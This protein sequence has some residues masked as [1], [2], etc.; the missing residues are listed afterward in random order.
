VIHAIIVTNLALLREGLKALLATEDGLDVT[1]IA[2][3]E[4]DVLAAARQLRPG[5][6]VVD[7]DTLGRHGLRY[8]RLLV[9][10]LPTTAVIALTARHSP[11]LLRQALAAGARGF[12]STEQ[13]P[14]ELVEV[15]R[16]VAEGDRMIHSVTALA[17]LA[18]MNS[19]LSERECEVLRLAAQGLSSDMI[20][21]KLFLSN[22]TVRNYLS[23]AVRKLGCANRLQA[24]RRAE[25]AGWL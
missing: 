22:G 19:P 18:T 2:G 7:L 20:A 24:A 16:R 5:V 1:G 8:V 11:C 3:T 23:I 13:P 15:I 25:E 9:D 12:A 21:R 14:A 17:T 4:R 10:E 6:C